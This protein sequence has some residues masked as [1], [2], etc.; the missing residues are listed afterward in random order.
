M[1]LKDQCYTFM[2]ALD[3]IVNMIRCVDCLKARKESLEL[4][5]K[6]QEIT[7]EHCIVCIDSCIH[8]YLNYRDISI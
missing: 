2:T 1:G 7:R 4:T 5:C 6:S 3:K 8:Q